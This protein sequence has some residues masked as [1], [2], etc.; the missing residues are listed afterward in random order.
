MMR[1]LWVAAALAATTT[2]APSLA[3]GGAAQGVFSTAQAE[4]GAAVYE[5]HCIACHAAGMAGGPGSPPLV[6]R[7][8]LIGW[9]AETLGVLFDHLKTT[10]PTGAAGTLTDQQYAD[11]MALILQ[12]NGFPPSAD[13]SEIAPDSPALSEIVIG[14]PE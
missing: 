14:A 9:Q 13:G 3:E 12:A 8:F 7:I 1:R 2:A 6:G 5:Q 10:M 11:A 4:R